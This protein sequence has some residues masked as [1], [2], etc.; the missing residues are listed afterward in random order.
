M[1]PITRVISLPASPSVSALTAGMPPATAASKRSTAPCASAISASAWPCTAMRALLAVTT[2]RPIDSAASTAARAGPASPPIS[3]TK[4]PMPSRRARATGSSLPAVAA[5]RHA[6]V[7]RAVP[8][9]DGG[10][11]HRPSG[12]GGDQVRVAAQDLD[13]ARAHGAE[14]RNAEAQGGGH[15]ALLA[16]VGAGHAGV[17]P[18]APS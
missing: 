9:A 17:T 1:T 2:S 4:T 3:S 10:D 13:H 15:R 18:A 14:P 12:A 7:A 11:L 8:G 16:R 5:E 6:P